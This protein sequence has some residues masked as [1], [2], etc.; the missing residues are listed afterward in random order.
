MEEVREFSLNYI[1]LNLKY[2]PMEQE[3]CINVTTDFYAE[4]NYDFTKNGYS[5]ETGKLKKGSM[6]WLLHSQ[7]Y[8]VADLYNEEKRNNSIFLKSLQEEI[9]NVS[10]DM[11]ILTFF[12]KVSLKDYFSRK[13]GSVH[14]SKNTNCGLYDP[15]SGAGSV[16]GIKLERSLTIPK[17]HVF[18]YGI[19]GNLGYSVNRIYG[20]SEDFWG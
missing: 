8:T 5:T 1:S 6:L 7:G 16:L 3:I 2:N 19:D 13:N 14:I 4:S 15:W 9:E 17:K 12:I 20:A 11:N 18:D 10:S